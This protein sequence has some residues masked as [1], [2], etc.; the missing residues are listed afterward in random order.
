[1]IK[2]VIGSIFKKP[3][4]IKYVPGKAKM[5]KGFRG[6][7]KFDPSKCVGC[8]MCMR[9]CPSG[10]IVIR[11]IG[12]KQFEAE[13]DLGKCVFCGQCAESCFKKALEIT[14]GFELAQ[15]DKAKLKVIFHVEAQ[16]DLFEKTEES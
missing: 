5:P 13:F 9:D 14:E 1:M 6:Q 8:K 12:D 16:E 4:T 7:I 3:A 15:L 11:K 10:A 2:E